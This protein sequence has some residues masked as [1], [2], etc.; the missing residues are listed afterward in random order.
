LCSSRK[1]LDPTNVRRILY[2]TPIRDGKNCEWKL[3][4]VN[5][6]SSNDGE[7]YLIINAHYNEQMYAPS[8]F[9]KKDKDRRNVYMWYDKKKIHFSD[10]FKW[11]IECFNFRFK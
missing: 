6:P 8:F 2:T 1:H 9:F 3:I 5:S 10:S 7:N 11:I 4:R